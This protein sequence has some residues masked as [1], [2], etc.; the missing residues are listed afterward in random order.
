MSTTLLAPKVI[1]VQ[2]QTFF[3]SDTALYFLENDGVRDL[4]NR[5][6]LY[7]QVHFRTTRSEGCNTGSYQE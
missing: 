5:G 4:V 6:N 2:I 1:H 3:L 7:S